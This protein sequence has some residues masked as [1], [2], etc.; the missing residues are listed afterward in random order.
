ME[1]RRVLLRLAQAVGDQIYIVM[2]LCEKSLR[3]RFR[4]CE[5]AG[6]R[7]GSQRE[8][9]A[10]IE[11]AATAL[12][13]LPQ[14]DILHRDI[15]PHNILIRTGFAKVADCGLA[16]LLPRDQSMQKTIGGGTP[17]YMPPEEWEGQVHKNGDQY[18]L[19]ATYVEL[20]RGVPIYET[21]DILELGRRHV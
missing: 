14:R 7:G 17:M 21:Q 11:H 5:K 6:E 19:A 4:E 10:Y 16:R 12:D 8:L 1:V 20:R 9:L 3:D 18:S 15:K 2:D 13:F